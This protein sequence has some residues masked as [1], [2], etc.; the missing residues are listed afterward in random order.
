[1]RK[2]ARVLALST[3]LL[4][5]CVLAVRDGAWDEDGHHPRMP[6]LEQRVAELDRR[7]RELE[8]CMAACPMSCCSNEQGE[9]H[10]DAEHEGHEG[11]PPAPPHP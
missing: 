11:H 4:P 5:G 10:E 6:P 1:M 8:E 3:L 7:V 2:F 9:K